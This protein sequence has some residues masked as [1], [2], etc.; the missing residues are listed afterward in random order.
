MV[1]NWDDMEKLIYTTYN[2]L[3]CPP[4]QHALLMTEAPWNPKAN[5]EKLTELVF[6]SFGVPKFYLGVQSVLSLNATGRTTGV[7]IESG[8]IA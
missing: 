5:R 4:G 6:E 3:I 2:E 8:N 7:V 1:T